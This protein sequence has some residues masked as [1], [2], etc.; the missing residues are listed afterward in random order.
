MHRAETLR[1]R[2]N[3]KPHKGRTVVRG[4]ALVEYMISL[5]G[6]SGFAV[7]ELR[8]PGTG[9]TLGH[10]GVDIIQNPARFDAFREKRSVIAAPAGT[11]NQIP[12]LKIE[13]VFEGFFL[14][15]V[16]MGPFISACPG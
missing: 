6:Y 2:E 9:Y 12:D 4:I 5:A 13:P 7:T 14:V 16:S 10:H 1:R 11:F 15:K 3:T 8:T